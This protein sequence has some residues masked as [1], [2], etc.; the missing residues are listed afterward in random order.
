ML[1]FCCSNH[2]LKNME[3]DFT[4]LGETAPE[5]RKSS[6]TSKTLLS[7]RKIT[8]LDPLSEF[9]LEMDPLSRAVMES[10]SIDT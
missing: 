5:V 6:L 3:E 2:I 10:V 1:S 7:S 9:A 8:E 4:L